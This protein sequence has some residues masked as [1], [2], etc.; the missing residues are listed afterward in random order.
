MSE[1]VPG[2]SFIDAS[3]SSL[4]TDIFEEKNAAPQSS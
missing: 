2:N 3:C 4:S 1:N